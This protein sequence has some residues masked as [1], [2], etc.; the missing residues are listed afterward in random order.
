MLNGG[1][2]GVG[3]LDCPLIY[4]SQDTGPLFPGVQLPGGRQGGVSGV[5]YGEKWG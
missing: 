2:E 3:L 4:S 5:I 1:M